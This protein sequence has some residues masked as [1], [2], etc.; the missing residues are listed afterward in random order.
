VIERT[1]NYV[2]KTLTKTLGCKMPMNLRAISV[3]T[4]RERDQRKQTGVHVPSKCECEVFS[5]KLYA[6]KDANETRKGNKESD[7]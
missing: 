7:E 1:W 3:E 4:K 6:C 5:L 2:R